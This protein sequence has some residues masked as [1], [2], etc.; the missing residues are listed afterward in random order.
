MTIERVLVFIFFW[1]L[2]AVLMNALATFTSINLLDE[3]FPYFVVL[4]VIFWSLSLREM[5]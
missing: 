4:F 5:N 1:F 2:G 3:L